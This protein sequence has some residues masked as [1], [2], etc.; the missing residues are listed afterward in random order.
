MKLRRILSTV[1]KAWTYVGLGTLAVF[2]L[3]LSVLALTQH[4]SAPVA[5]GAPA[6]R[7]ESPAATQS[8][9]PDPAASE[10]PTGEPEAPAAAV[11]PT[12]H[13]T[14]L[15][16]GTLIRS[17]T[18]Q[19]NGPAPVVESSTD[20]GA[21]WAVGDTSAAAPTQVLRLLSGGVAQAIVFDQSCQPTGMR[22]VDE[23]SVW[24]A[25][26][27]LLQGSWYFNPAAPASLHAPSGE[28]TLPC[29][30]LA[31]SAW[32]TTAI[33]LCDD[34]TAVTTT[35]GAA[36]WSERV[37]APGAVTANAA[38]DGFRVL[39][40][41]TAPDC[42]GVQVAPLTD[43]IVQPAGGCLTAEF[44]P[45]DVALAGGGDGS[46]AAWVGDVFALSADGGATWG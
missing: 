15:N 43:G 6:P 24:V 3:I 1:P 11:V 39:V 30:A 33:A 36:T 9:S 23:G 28:T 41:G 17:T 18:G 20:S 35:N 32:D 14:M 37:P 40:R 7:T 44:A 38:P 27:G 5:T 12:R 46:I 26:P 2:V 22:S 13:L 16:T 19:C 34:G 21:T 31:F 25:S 45:G 4:R 29:T 8:A 10:E 42:A